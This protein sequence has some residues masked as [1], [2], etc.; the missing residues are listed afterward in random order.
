MKVLLCL[1]LLCSLSYSQIPDD[2]IVIGGDIF[3]DFNEDLEASKV[4]E[5]ERFYRYSRFFGVNLGL[6]MTTFTGNRG[7]VFQDQNPSYAFSL[8][9]FLDFQNV[10]IMGFEYS[11]HFYLIDT[12]LNG[13][14]NELLGLVEQSFLRSFF[15]FRYYIDTQD[16]G[17]AITYS[18]PYLVG[19]FEYWYQTTSFEDRVNRSDEKEGAVGFGIGAGLEFPIK[20]KESYFNVE[21]L[22]HIVA[23]DDKYSQD[24]A[25]IPDSSSSS[26]RTD[27]GKGVNDL[28]GDVITIFAAYNISW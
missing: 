20:I 3:S 17:T 13:S 2:D 22:Y 28:R 4:M 14:Q 26:N 21:F 16:L 5:D 25:A 7:K 15:G 23:F 6:G 12:F 1:I 10:F 27:S 24:Y 18:N 8:M 9:Y 19:R 11:K